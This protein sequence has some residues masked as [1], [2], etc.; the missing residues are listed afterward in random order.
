VKDL[1]KILGVSRGAHPSVIKNAYRRLARQLHPDT[2]GGDKAKTER[3]KEVCAAYTILSD[4]QRRSEYDAEG[5]KSPIE[6]KGSIFGDLFDEMVARVIDEGINSGNINDVLSQFMGVVKDVEKNMPERIARQTKTPSGIMDFVEMM[7][8][9]H[10][11][12][13]GKK[14]PKS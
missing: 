6:K 5:L 2:N 8:D 12:V 11:E 7:L 4:A 9:Q 14:R 1:Y 10:L 13:G 3:F